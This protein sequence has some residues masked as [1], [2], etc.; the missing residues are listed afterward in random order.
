MRLRKNDTVTARG[1]CRRLALRED[2]SK[3]IEST[4]PES[5]FAQAL[6]ILN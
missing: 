6:S 3:K 5:R 1:N 4:D 2:Y